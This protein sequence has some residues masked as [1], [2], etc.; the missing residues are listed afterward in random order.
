MKKLRDV[1]LKKLEATS[2]RIFLSLSSER[3][4][5]LMIV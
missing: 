1:S 2:N 4:M 5:T 3:E